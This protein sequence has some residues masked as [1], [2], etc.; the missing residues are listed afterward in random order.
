[1]DKNP[2]VKTVI[3]KIDTVGEESKYRTFNYEVLA[4]P[5]DMNVTLREQECTYKFNYAKVYW[6][7]RLNTEHERLV[8]LFREGEA[9]CDVMAGIGPFAIPAGKKK[10]FVWAN[11]LNPE[12]YKALEE[13]IT[14]NKV[15]DFV[16]SFN[17]D[18]RAFIIE[19]TGKLYRED[20]AITIRPKLSRTQKMAPR[21]SHPPGRT[22]SQPRTFSHFVMNLPAT[23]ITFL[24]SF[25]GLYRNAGIVE[26]EPLPSIH[27]YCFNTKSDDNKAESEKICEHISDLLGF[28][29]KLG[30][31]QVEGEITVHDVRDVAPKKRM[32]CASFKLPREVAYRDSA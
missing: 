18:G 30:D 24:P 20:R 5:G 17:Q 4:G 23:A 22:I 7:S 19:A 21:E 9:V 2:A 32:F 13:G 29:F 28:K 12:S 11:D 1:M 16:R 27:V 8:Q 14:L 31:G 3:N 6:N 15:E 26:D 25:V 10:V